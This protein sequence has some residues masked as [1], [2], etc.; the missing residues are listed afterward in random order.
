V[1]IEREKTAIA[2]REV[3]KPLQMIVQHGIVAPGRT[4]LD[5]GCGRGDDIAALREGGIEAW[6][7][8]PYYARDGRLDEA[9]VVNLGFVVNV[10]EDP[11]E[12]SQTLRCAWSLCRRTLTVS[13]ML[14]GRG[15]PAVSL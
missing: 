14:L 11:E 6:G 1:N 2:R 12:R 13:A 9:D 15:P 8:D 3:S 5:Y 7:W 10:I 4:L